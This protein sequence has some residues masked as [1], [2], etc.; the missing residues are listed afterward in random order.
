MQGSRPGICL[1]FLCRVFHLLWA[2]HLGLLLLVPKLLGE[3][4]LADQLRSAMKLQPAWLQR[5]TGLL[6]SP[7]LDLCSMASVPAVWLPQV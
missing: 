4:G 1:F 6:M 3:W 5:L 7:L 2:L